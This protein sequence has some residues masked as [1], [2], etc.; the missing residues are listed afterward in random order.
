MAVS[1]IVAVLER[2]TPHSTKSSLAETAPDAFRAGLRTVVAHWGAALEWRSDGTVSAK[3]S[4]GD[5]EAIATASARCALSMR[6]LLDCA[7]AIV[8]SASDADDLRER[9]ASLAKLAGDGV[10]L[11]ETTAGLLKEGFELGSDAHGRFLRA[12]R[13]KTTTEAHSLTPGDTLGRYVIEDWLGEGGMG[14][15]FRAHDTKLGRKVALKVL[16]SG[17]GGTDAEARFFR[18]ARVAATFTHPNVV[19]LFDV[20]DGADGEPRHIAMELVTGKTLRAFIGDAGVPIERRIRWLVDAARAL[21]AAHAAGLVHRDV[22][23]ENVMVRDDGVVKV[24][25]FGIA[26]RVNDDVESEIAYL[27]TLT[28]EGTVLGTPLYMAPEQMRGDPVDARVDQFAWAVMAYELLTGVRPWGKDTFQ[29]LARMLTTEPRGIRS[30]RPEVPEGFASAIERAL[31][32]DAHERFPSMDALLAAI[33]AG[34]VSRSRNPRRAIGVLALLAFVAVGTGI[35]VRVAKRSRSPSVPAS[36][37]TQPTSHGYA[38]AMSAW[39][40]GSSV[41]AKRTMERAVENERGLGAG[42][43]RLALWGVSPTVSTPT[44]ART[45]FAKAQSLQASLDEHDRALLEAFEPRMRQ[46][47]ETAEWHDRLSR[48]AERFPDDAEIAWWLVRA[49]RMRGEDEAA[50]SIL[51]RVLSKNPSSSGLLLAAKGEHARSRNRLPDALVA[52]DECLR[53]SPSAIDC[54]EGRTRVRGTTGDCDG[55]ESDARNWAALD[56]MDPAPHDVIASVL[57]LRKAPRE[58]VEETLRAKAE[59]VPKEQRAEIERGHRVLVAM[60]FADFDEA[61]RVSI[62]ANALVP[63]SAGLFPHLTTISWIALAGDEAKADRVVGDASV[64][65]LKRARAWTPQSVNQAAYPLF[66]LERAYH[67]GSISREEFVAQ[68]ADWLAVGEAAWERAGKPKEKSV[69]W[70]GAYG[71]AVHDEADAKEALEALPAYLPL[72]APGAVSPEI[73]LSIAKTYAYGKRADEAIPYAGVLAHSCHALDLLPGWMWGHVL[74]GIA[75]E[76]KGQ[77]AQA[78]N[79]YRVVVDRW[80]KAKPASRTAEL[81][82]ARLLAIEKTAK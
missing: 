19:G 57:W 43:L 76:Q 45:A 11:D 30:I 38:D 28:G 40:A 66:V 31:S 24:L 29:S 56:P 2:T 27:A 67:H 26:R 50:V 73:D 6:A 80:G 78:A 13:S 82:R 5:L 59:K 25:D 35:I 23:P 39:R 4:G 32:R 12:A 51:D 18:E 20:G 81:A 22:K 37:S 47:P 64:D 48:L 75:L 49:K 55:M 74:L 70:S 10:R 60:A 58:S 21:S 63:A 42:F 3:L 15:V 68:R 46:I 77:L 33:D 61:L 72:P 7:I 65:F 62:E 52:Y 17:K 53:A 14:A 41:L 36:S 79:E 16:A 9:A 69:L 1:V 54:F 8:T 71:V 44:D 34:T